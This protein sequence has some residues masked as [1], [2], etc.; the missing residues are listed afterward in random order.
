MEL[1]PEIMAQALAGLGGLLLIAEVC[2]I[3]GTIN[4]NRDP[5][6]HAKRWKGL[7]V[8]VCFMTPAV[9]YCFAQATYI[10]INGP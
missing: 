6:V 4:R 5:R 2:I 3:I 8:V 9:V 1:T 7:I 10:W